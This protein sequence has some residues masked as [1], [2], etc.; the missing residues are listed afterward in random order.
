[1]QSGE[2]LYF[3]QYGNAITNLKNLS[4]DS[5]ILI[6]NPLPFV[7]SYSEVETGAVLALI[8][9][10]GRLEISIREGNA[11]RELGL[12]VGQKVQVVD[13]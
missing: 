4:P 2:I 3:D 12:K 1:M 9:S 10:T 11:Q 5:Q 6:E 7:H 13:D 8:G